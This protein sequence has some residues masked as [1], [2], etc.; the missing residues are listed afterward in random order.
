[1][2]KNEHNLGQFDNRNKAIA[3]ATDTYIKFLDSDDTLNSICIATT[4]AAMQVNKNASIAVPSGNLSVAPTLS[5]HQ[6]LQ[7]HYTYGNHL[8]FGPT[9]TLFT[10]TS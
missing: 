10:K 4:V 1:M 3:L 7:L 6:S 5:P 8:C 9:K 2:Y